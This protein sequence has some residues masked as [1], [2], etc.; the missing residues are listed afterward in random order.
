MR[1]RYG[2][3][4]FRGI[5]AKRVPYT[6]EEPE[7][8]GI[9]LQLC[10]TRR[11]GYTGSTLIMITTP[12]PN[13]SVSSDGFSLQIVFPYRFIYKEARHEMF[14]FVE[15]LAGNNPFAIYLESMSHWQPPHDSEPITKEERMRII[16]N[17]RSVFRHQGYEIDVEP[18]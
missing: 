7:C 14:I 2:Q 5:L 8:D 1:W 15:P 13:L 18:P 9:Y 3:R 12:S 10:D 11:N 4:R 17:I 16:E 6:F